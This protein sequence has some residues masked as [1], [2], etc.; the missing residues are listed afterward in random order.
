[1]PGGCS[2]NRRSCACYKDD[3]SIGCTDDAGTRTS[4]C[5][6][7]LDSLR[8][9]ISLFMRVI[10]PKTGTHFW[11][12]RFSAC[13]E[14]L[15][16]LCR[17]ISLFMRVIF[18]KTGTHFWVTRAR[19][20]VQLVARGLLAW[21][22]TG[23]GF[24]IARAEPFAMLDIKTMTT[25]LPDQLGS[26]EIMLLALFGGAMSFALMSAFWLI[27]ERTRISL[28]NK[29]LEARAADLQAASQRHAA[30]VNVRDQR[31]VVW[32]GTDDKPVILG[33]LAETDAPEE[34]AEFLAFGNWITPQS[35]LVFEKALSQ[36]REHA[37]S[38]DLA[39]MTKRGRALQTQGRTSGGHAFV[40][41]T[42]LTGEREALAQ[43]K[44]EHDRLAKCFDTIQGLFEA[45]K[46]PVWIRNDHGRLIWVNGSYAEAVET[47]DSDDAVARN[48]GLLDRK[49]RTLIERAHETERV[50]RGTQPAVIAGDRRVM[51]IVDVK[52]DHGVAGMALDRSDLEQVRSTLR[53]T[54]DS[55]AQTLNELA[56]AVAI[57]DKSQIL[58]FYNSSFQQLF[59]LESGFL[60][61]APNNG[62]IL[63]ALRDNR[64]L[65]EHPDWRKWKRNQL[66]AYQAL[67]AS[68]EWWHLSDG[69]TIRVITNPH[70]QGGVTWIFENVTKELELKSNYNSLIR[71]QG[72]TLDHLQESVAVFGS[73][74]R[75][76]LHNPAFLHLW[77]LNE[78]PDQDS[79]HISQVCEQSA[80]LVEDAE[81]WQTIR[82]AI[83]G[84]GE[85]RDNVTGRM[86]MVTGNMLDF[87][88]VALPDGQTMLTFADVTDSVNMERAL[89]DRNE[90]LEQADRLKNKFIQHVSYELR[91][92]LTSISGFTELLFTPGMGELSSKQ[93]EYLG[94]I[95][96][97]TSVLT[98]IVNDILDLASVDAG[99]MYLEIARVPVAEV[100]ETCI[101]QMRTVLDERNIQIDV[102]IEHNASHITGDRSRIRQVLGNLIDNAVSVSSPGQSIEIASRSADGYTELSVCDHGPGISET[103][104][105][106]IFSRFEGHSIG[107][108]R[109]GPG[110]GLSIVESFVELHGGTIKVDSIP[111][112]GA[113]FICRFPTTP[114][115]ALAAAQ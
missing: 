2:Q 48:I 16:S 78:L 14:A 77:Q 88:L 15:D 6:Q 75:L 51:E 105:G 23:L 87:A 35:A 57:F 32:K 31:V 13:H 10:F 33:T 108:R 66:G 113:Q 59:K 61:S 47:S 114:P 50:Y 18:P 3:R 96:Q 55:H 101:N 30:L 109:S 76:R 85:E 53:Q 104:Q 80:G 36:L 100:I 46:A 49:G 65:P 69:Q 64:K 67:E 21:P 9:A 28:E 40:R 82:T 56:T 11:V 73:D 110:L 94:Y 90:A 52:T 98:S 68:E 37:E 83:T 12:T 4:A 79:I 54:V 34:R 86:A 8:R 22:L 58:S 93:R 1:M 60:E 71:V 17:A 45:L 81:Q 39:L 42:E 97:S 38:F 62:A 102:K 99:T 95:S 43:L 74:G 111:G 24:D 63:D 41:F 91:A 106:W 84:L 25:P 112:H 103:D 19:A 92:P 26:F 27:R 70:S 115:Q 89:T 5:H 44:I 20:P 29:S 7:A 107:G 72:E